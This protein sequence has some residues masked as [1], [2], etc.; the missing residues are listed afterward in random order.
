[1]KIEEA[2]RY[3][4]KKIAQNEFLWKRAPSIQK[5]PQYASTVLCF[6]K[7]RSPMCPNK[8]E[9]VRHYGGAGTGGNAKSCDLKRKLYV[10]PSI[11][12]ENFNIFRNNSTHIF[13]YHKIN[14]AFWGR[15]KI[16]RGQSPDFEFCTYNLHF[17]PHTL[18]GLYVFSGTFFGKKRI[19]VSFYDII[20]PQ[21]NWVKSG[22]GVL[23]VQNLALNRKY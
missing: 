4:Q 8:H 9:Q 11:S 6:F 21:K 3:G 18:K 13:I 2:L 23:G 17:R 15:T 19:F 5:R 7:N 14:E 20:Y 12:L 16:F 1:M 22:I 10:A